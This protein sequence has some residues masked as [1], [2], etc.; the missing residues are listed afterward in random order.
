MPE[1]CPMHE[2]KSMRAAIFVTMFLLAMTACQRSGTESS[3]SEALERLAELSAARA[4]SS[5]A[6]TAGRHAQN[7]ARGAS[8]SFL[9]RCDRRTEADRSRYVSCV[10]EAGDF[11]EARKCQ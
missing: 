11:S 4:Q 9:E 5:T 7:I 3:C 2:L 6:S 10:L 8:A 1:V